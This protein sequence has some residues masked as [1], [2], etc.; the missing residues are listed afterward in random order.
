MAITLALHSIPESVLPAPGTP[1][2]RE[3]FPVTKTT[4]CSSY[5]QEVQVQPLG[6]RIR[7]A[8]RG[9]SLAANPQFRLHLPR[10]HNPTAV[11]ILHQQLQNGWAETRRTHPPLPPDDWWTEQIDAIL[12]IFA[13]A[14]EHGEAVVITQAPLRQRNAP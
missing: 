8:I 5:I 9:E 10:F 2:T 13:W 12:A 14:A 4:Y 3:N 6:E 7:E 1:L 11:K